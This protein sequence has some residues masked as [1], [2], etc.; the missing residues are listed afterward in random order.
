MKKTHNQG[1]RHQTG[2]T[3][4]GDTLQ[5]VPTSGGRDGNST[6]SAAILFCFIAGLFI[7]HASPSLQI[8]GGACEQ[9][10]APFAR[11]NVCTRHRTEGVTES[12]GREG[13]NGSGGGGGNGDGGRNGDGNGVRGG[14]E[15]VN[16]D[17]DEDGA[18]AGMAR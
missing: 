8:G 2:R 4:V 5:R 1:A 18:G 14:N 9:P 3:Q 6:S 16:R 17:G 12:E 13:A 15:D 7:P 11:P 10:T